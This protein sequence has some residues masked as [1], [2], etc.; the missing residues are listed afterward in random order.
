MSIMHFPL[1][2]GLKTLQNT[3]RLLIFNKKLIKLDSD[4]EVT[5]FRHV[6]SGLT[7]LQ[8]TSCNVGIKF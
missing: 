1:T 6:R 4:D 2:W 3:T 5:A 7:T 8:V